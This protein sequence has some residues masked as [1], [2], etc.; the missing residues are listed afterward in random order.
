MIDCV[1]VDF[2]DSQDSEQ[3]ES[4]TAELQRTTGSR[5]AKLPCMLLED[6]EMFSIEGL[7][8]GYIADKVLKEFLFV[9]SLKPYSIGY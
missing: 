4:A 5:R 1:M 3:K 2:E 7:I 8:L 9:N 6:G